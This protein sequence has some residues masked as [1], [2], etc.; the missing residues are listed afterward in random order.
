MFADVIIPLAVPRTYTWSIP[1]RLQ[2]QMH[3]GVRVEVELRK[4]RYAGVVKTIHQNK[5]AAFEPKGILNVLDA[6]PI[7]HKE[8]LKLWEWMA[9]YYMCSEGEVMAA[10]LPAHFKLSSETILLFN[11]E[12]GEDFTMLDH[13]EYL[14]AEALIIRKELKVARSATD[15]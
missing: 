5:P 14:L 4:K 11:E 9:N 12:A 8:Q 15:T 7:I 6:E 10:A 13:D 2:E 1:A 3:V